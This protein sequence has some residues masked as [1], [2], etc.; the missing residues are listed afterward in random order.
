MANRS[1]PNDG[2]RLSQLALAR[3]STGET[4]RIESE[5]LKAFEADVSAAA[6]AMPAFDFETLR[7]ASHRIQDPRPTAETAPQSPLS[8]PWW[9]TWMLGPAALVGLLL[10]MVVTPPSALE[11]RVK[12]GET[13]LSYYLLRRGRVL[14]GI[15]KA[16][17][18]PGDRIQFSYRA[19]QHE[20]MVL[21]NV[22]GE[23]TFTV[24]YPAEGQ[25]PMTVIPNDRHVLPGAIELDDA[26]G[27][28]A[29]V[30]VFGPGSVDAALKLVR[31]TW[32]FGGHDALE[33]LEKSDPAVA[34]V[35]I[36]KKD[37]K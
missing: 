10:F 22:D 23:G 1:Q 18:A 11:N 19:H 2:S 8:G 9:R 35:L 29:F 12:G 13:D 27:P 7:A 36:E 16:P 33:A 3:M 5:P 37:A 4:E 15:E 31:Q 28:E 25:E 34:V 26:P 6:K 32:E 21:I 20:T 24:F 30:A 17:L 14:P